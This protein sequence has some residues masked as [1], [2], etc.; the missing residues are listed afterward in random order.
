MRF[1]YRTSTG[2]EGNRDSSFGGH[3][4]NRAYTKTQRKGAVTLRRLNQSYL[5]VLEGLLWRCGL[6]GAHCRDSHWKQ[7][8]WKVPLGLVLLEVTINPTIDP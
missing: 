6:A 4:Q 7:Q 2:L 1:D 3:K 8:S 5:L